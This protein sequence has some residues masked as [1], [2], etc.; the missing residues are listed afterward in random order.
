MVVLGLGSNCGDRL[1]Y[2]R[3]A[4][5]CLKDFRST[6]PIEIVAISPIYESDALLP[7]GAPESWNLPFL[8]LNLVCKTHLS[9]LELLTQIKLI[10]T[11]LGRKKRERWAPREIDIDIL[12]FDSMILDTADLKLP[13]GS[14]LDRPFAL[15]PFADLLP[16]WRWPKPG[17]LQGVALAE[18]VSPWRHNPWETVPFRTRRSQYYLTELMG[19]LNITPDSF[20]DGGLYFH[21]E[22]MIKQ[23]QE[24]VNHG[25]GVIDL[26]A[27][28]TRPG[29]AH[30]T[31]DE[32]WNRLEPSLLSLQELFSSLKHPPQISIDTR[33]SEVASKAIQRGAN[34]I[35]DVTGFE[36]PAMREAVAEC[37]VDLVVMHSLSIPPHK[38]K[39]L[40]SQIDPIA[41]LLDWAEQRISLLVKDG[42]SRERIIIDP[43]LGF[44]KTIEQSWEILRR[45]QEL[46]QLRVRILIG[47]SR[48]S[49]LSQITQ[50]PFAERDIET[51]ALSLDLISKG[52]NYLRIHNAEI[53]TRSLKAWTQTNGIIRC[54]N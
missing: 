33:H 49:F 32:E 26:G 12:A 50:Q 3:K 40:S 23:A 43:G 20:S 9:P 47:H 30:V 29:A 35:N 13:H 52:M 19:I 1:S 18:I 48:K 14:L 31:A 37:P 34:W 10:E 17:P 5:Q 4:I 11:Q 45:A 15:L 41:Q 22:T 28:S 6:Y 7:D 8:N 39:V 42:I 46:H 36:D 16:Q 54:K 38:S 24:L 25:I 51:A 27:E 44:G 21:P 53:H 2:L